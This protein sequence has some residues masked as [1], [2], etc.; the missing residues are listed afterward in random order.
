[1]KEQKV[2]VG[3]FEDGLYAEI[4]RRDLKAAGV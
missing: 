3:E 1:M 4:A 2:I